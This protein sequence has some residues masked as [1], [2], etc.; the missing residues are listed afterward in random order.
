VI[1]DS[2]ERLAFAM[3]AITGVALAQAG[4]GADLTFLQWRVLVV[5][6]SGGPPLRVHQLAAAIGASPSS[7]SRLLDR[8]ELR[9]LVIVTLD[10]Q[11]RRGRLVTLSPRGRQVRK[12]VVE[13]R[14][15]ILAGDMRGSLPA[16]LEDGL[17]AIAES[18]QHWVNPI[19][20]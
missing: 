15:Q 12:D 13:R 18:L 10:P 7:T 6:G 8:L 5:V 20:R 11:D 16:D 4:H 17:E 14:R 19:G 3:V 1:I 9:E 2:L